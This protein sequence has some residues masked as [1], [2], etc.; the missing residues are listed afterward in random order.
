M[1]GVPANL[2]KD[3]GHWIRR[4]YTIT[5]SAGGLKGTAKVTVVAAPAARISTQTTDTQGTS[6]LSPLSEADAWLADFEVK[7]R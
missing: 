7:G 4:P 5:A 2:R 3:A 1:S 6:V